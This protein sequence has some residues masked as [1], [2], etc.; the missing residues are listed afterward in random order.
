MLAAG[1]KVDPITREGLTP[2]HMALREGNEDVAR[3][4][5]SYGAAVNT[6]DPLPLPL[7]LPLALAVALALAPTLA[8]T[9]TPIGWT[10]EH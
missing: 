4:L 6:K 8:L 9:P 2:T 7:Y 1:S 3:L 5:V 10:C